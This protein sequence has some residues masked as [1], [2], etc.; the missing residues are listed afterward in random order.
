MASNKGYVMAIQ[1]LRGSRLDHY[2]YG[3]PSSVLSVENISSHYELLPAEVKAR[4]TKSIIHPE[5]L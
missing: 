4:I 3:E 1:T 5:D 2:R